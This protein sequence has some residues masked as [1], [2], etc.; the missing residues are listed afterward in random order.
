MFK[1]DGIL[2]MSLPIKVF[3]PI[4]QLEKIC[5]IFSNTDYIHKAKLEQNKIDKFKHIITYVM[6]GVYFSI[7]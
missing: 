3:D 2:K 5:T 1:G 7:T 4:S 6:T